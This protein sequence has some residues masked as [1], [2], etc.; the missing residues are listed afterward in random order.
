MMSADNASGNKLVKKKIPK[1]TPE[2]EQFWKDYL[3]QSFGTRRFTRLTKPVKKMRIARLIHEMMTETT[4]V[5]RK[6]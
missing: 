5:Y 6:G 1:F 2:N 3:F 4:I